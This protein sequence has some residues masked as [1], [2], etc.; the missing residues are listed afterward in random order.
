LKGKFQAVKP[1][2][3][4]EE[5][6]PFRDDEYADGYPLNTDTCF[7]FMSPVGQKMVT[8][9]EKLREQMKD[10]EMQAAFMRAMNG[11]YRH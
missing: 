11:M 10:T 1:Q 7:H 8:F 2:P 6:V 4:K 5:L 3:V 9:G